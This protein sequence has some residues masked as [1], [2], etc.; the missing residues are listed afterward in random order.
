[1]T[2]SGAT[3]LFQEK[4]K[5]IGFALIAIFSSF[6]ITPALAKEQQQMAVACCCSS[7]QIRSKKLTERRRRRAK[8]FHSSS[9]THKDIHHG[10]GGGLG[11]NCWRLVFVIA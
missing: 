10:L 11:V 4:E 9:S 5:K 3:V 1:V 6:N 7:D 8:I 2:E